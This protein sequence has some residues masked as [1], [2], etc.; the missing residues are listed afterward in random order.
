M[1]A[2]YEKLKA[3]FEKLQKPDGSKDTPAKSC[4]DANMVYCNMDTGASCVQ[5]KPA[6][7]QIFS[8]ISEEKY[9]WVGDIE[10][11]GFDINYKADSN[12]MNY[13][14]LLSS[15]AEQTITFHCKS[16]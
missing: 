3:S 1:K 13:L 7:S 12:Q 4:K 9:M 5:A 11:D 8:I 6:T 14:Q 10:D 16:T 15:K 2:A